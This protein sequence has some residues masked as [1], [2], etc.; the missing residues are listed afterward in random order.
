MDYSSILNTIC[1]LETQFPVNNWKLDGTPIW[2]LLRI[3]LNFALRDRMVLSNRT[4]APKIECI[5]NN[6]QALPTNWNHNVNAIFYSKSHYREKL[7]DLYWD[8]HCDPLRMILEKQ[9]NSTILI[10]S[11]GTSQH[12]YPVAFEE[13]FYTDPNDSK[14]TRS[15]L[16]KTRERIERLRLKLSGARWDKYEQFLKELIQ[17]GIKPNNYK[18]FSRKTTIKRFLKLKSKSTN[19]QKFLQ[20]SKPKIVFITCYYVTESLAVVW[21]CRR[22]KIPIVDIQHGMQYNSAYQNWTAKTLGNLSF[23]PTHF[24]VWS[25]D[26]KN[27][28]DKWVT[29]TNTVTCIQGGYPWSNLVR[30]THP[31]VFNN[32]LKKLKGDRK[33]GLITLP[34]Y[35]PDIQG[36]LVDAIKRS[37]QKILWLIRTHPRIPEA[38]K[39]C[40]E[41]FD[42]ASINSETLAYASNTPLVALLGDCDLHL[43]WESSVIHEAYLLDIPS[44]AIERDAEIIFPAAKE[45]GLLLI[46]NENTLLE[47]INKLS[48]SSLQSANK[49]PIE[50][51]S[52]LSSLIRDAQSIYSR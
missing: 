8:R 37:S 48:D 6:Y 47:K 40:I 2:P 10:E 1:D 14:N 29:N 12:K 15:S 41:K 11:S 23:C 36:Y 32:P 7:N 9:G 16:F 52:V 33:L 44:I 22:L 30:A 38:G 43:T 3:Q 46:A 20:Q 25:S 27:K 26:D 4:N 39:A 17:L 49:S 5:K 13:S 19:I 31:Q 18:S 24:W 51:D 50:E 21:A 45:A 34:T 42:I 28:L 35:E